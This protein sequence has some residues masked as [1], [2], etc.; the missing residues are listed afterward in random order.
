M[1][2]TV[3]GIEDYKLPHRWKVPER[4]S[5]WHVT[6]DQHSSLITHERHTPDIYPMSRQKQIRGFLRRVSLKWV[7]KDQFFL[8][9]LFMD[10][11]WEM[12]SKDT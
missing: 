5:L 6:F 8:M 3:L 10:R 11:Q 2:V 12:H 4:Q 9:W 1:K 7:K